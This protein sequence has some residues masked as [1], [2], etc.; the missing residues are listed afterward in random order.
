MRYSEKFN[1]DSCKSQGKKLHR[2]RNVLKPVLWLFFQ[3]NLQNNL[4][5]NLRTSWL[6]KRQCHEIFCF[7]FFY[8]SSSPKPLKITLESFWIFWKIPGDIRKSRCT[9]GINDTSSKF[10]TGI[11]DTCGK[12]ATCIN[13]TC[14]KFCH[15]F[16][17]CC[18]YWWRICHRC[19]RYPRQICHSGKHWEQYQTADNWKWTWRKKIIYMLTLLPSGVQKK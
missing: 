10:A 14:G 15:Q 3:T 19:P 17:W 5:F 18:W 16:R 12:F 2:A 8:E 6:V 7:R 9:T 13:D 1:F 11:N 4:I